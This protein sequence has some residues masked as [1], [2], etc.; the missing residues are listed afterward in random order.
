MTTTPM[1][2]EMDRVIWLSCGLATA[3][4]S[5]SRNGHQLRVT[6][7]SIHHR[8]QQHRYGKNKIH[9]VQLLSHNQTQQHPHTT[10]HNVSSIQQK[11]GRKS[12]RDRNLRR[13]HVGKFPPNSLEGYEPK[14][15]KCLLSTSVS[16]SSDSS[17]QE[18]ARVCSFVSVCT[19]G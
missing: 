4:N 8:Y 5:V 14:P 12:G 2:S 15:T 19:R 16:V 1:I 6:V 10:V 7:P 9:H 11:K 18:F 17:A 3:T 13:S